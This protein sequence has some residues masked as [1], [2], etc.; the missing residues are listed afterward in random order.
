MQND[1]CRMQNVTSRRPLLHS[2]FCILHLPTALYA[3]LALLVIPVYPHFPSPNEFSRWALAASIV[4]GH[5]LEVTRVAPLLGQNE[6]LA[7][8]GG[9]IYSNKAP[10]AALLGLPAYA[11]ARAVVGPPSPAT[12][13]VTLTA[14]RLLAATLPAVLLALLFAAAA[15]RLGAPPDRVTTGVAALL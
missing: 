11:L 4:D 6:D 7:E 9:R 14:M 13:R 5:T 8:V 1:E 10:G 12:M 2:A 3:A 15:A